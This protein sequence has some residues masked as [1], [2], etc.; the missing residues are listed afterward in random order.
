VDNSFFP[1]KPLKQ[2]VDS[3]QSLTQTVQSTTSP[4]NCDKRNGGDTT[5]FSKQ[6]NEER[7]DIFELQD[8]LLKYFC[9]N[10]P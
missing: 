3:S 4:K 5:D 2:N 1:A 10:F 7:C 9:L 8:I 6:H